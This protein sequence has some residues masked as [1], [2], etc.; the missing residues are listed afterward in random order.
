[1]YRPTVYAC[2]R[3]E[4]K[5][6]FFA[7]HLAPIDAFVIAYE[8]YSPVKGL[9]I[10]ILLTIVTNDAKPSLSIQAASAV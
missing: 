2:K 7:T 8:N 1:M 3:V 6:I 5:A 9:R 10:Y 4:S